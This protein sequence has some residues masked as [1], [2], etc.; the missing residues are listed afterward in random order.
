MATLVLT[1]VGSLVGGPLG[2][3]IGALAG[4]QI[5]AQ[6]IGSTTRDGPRLKE[7]A[8]ST[9]SYGQSIPRIHGKMRAPGSIIWATDLQESRETSGGGKGKP[10]TAAYSYSASF[11][12]ALSSRP[13]TGIGRIWADGNLLRG[14]AGDFKNEG[15]LRI[16][17]G[18]GDQNQ[19]PIIA[20]AQGDACPAFRQLAYA[21]FEDLQLADFGNRIPALTF[22][23]LGGTAPIQ[24][25]DLIP[26]QVAAAQ[27]SIALE[28]V[29]GFALEGGALNSALDIIDTAYPFACDTSMEMLTFNDPEHGAPVAVLP[30]PISSLED[31]DFGAA[32]GQLMQRRP[33][34]SAANPALRHYD[35]ERDYQPGIQRAEGPSPTI[36]QSV[37]DFPATMSANTAKSLAERIAQRGRWQRD[38]MMWRMAE[39]DPAI[40]PG[41]CVRVPDQAGE[42]MVAGWEWRETSIELELVRKRAGEVRQGGGD[43]GLPLLTPDV[44]PGPTHLRFFELPWDGAGSPNQPRMLAAATSTNGLTGASLHI[45]RGTALEAIAPVARANA[46]Q[47]RL[48]S[49]LEPSPSLRLEPGNW[50]DVVIDGPEATFLNASAE[51]IARGSNTALVGSEVLQFAR[52]EQ[53][54]STS[55]RLSGLLRGRGGTENIAQ[56]GHVA[57]AAFVLLDDRLTA[58]DNVAGF[59]TSASLAAIGRGDDVPVFAERMNTGLSL[60]PPPPVHP[61]ARMDGGLSLSWIRRARG[62]W[63]WPDEVEVPLVEEAEAYQIGVGPLTAPLRVWTANAPCLELTAEEWAA[64][65]AE[66]PGE[67]IWVRQIGSHAFSLPVRLTQI[68]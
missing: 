44:V 35:P 22:E 4:R 10:K 38:R 16:H 41:A 63:Y 17:L 50:F 26:G 32:D 68:P 62:S 65:Q 23:V 67:D 7:L 11:A 61:D 39:L 31:G 55:W 56:A 9:S 21:V 12:I 28:G 37:L 5:D 36:G 19:D 66:A 48:L 45:A 8:V 43:A 20:A 15:L 24:L 27:G 59:D 25:V 33:Q 14:T 53:R 40:R 6:L 13:I 2:G 18:H 34:S 3:A 64:L 60:R 1:A 47:G 42:W 54:D 57:G 30:E 29:Q 49:S 51:A 46:I 52:A 58:I